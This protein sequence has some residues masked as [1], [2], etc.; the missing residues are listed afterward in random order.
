MDATLF[1]ISRISS[2]GEV[3]DRVVEFTNE[4]KGSRI[5]YVAIVTEVKHLHFA[6]CGYD[7]VG[8]DIS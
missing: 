4:R 1:M 7:V 2:S 5:P 3:R 8:I 6:K